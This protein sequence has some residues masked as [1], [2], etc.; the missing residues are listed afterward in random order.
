[1]ASLISQGHNRFENYDDL[2]KEVEERIN[3]YELD[4]KQN[5]FNYS[6]NNPKTYNINE[7]IKSLN[8]NH[9]LGIL[10]SVFKGDSGHDVILRFMFCDKYIAI[11]EI[12]YA[13]RTYF[14]YVAINNATFE[15]LEPINENGDIKL[16]YNNDELLV[17]NVIGE[18]Y[19]KILLSKYSSMK[20]VVLLGI[21]QKNKE[22]NSTYL[23]EYSYLIKNIIYNA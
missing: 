18:T 21:D 8:D 19:V 22:T 5:Y 16:E 9:K 13:D 10:E 1:K 15:I 4:N 17:K 23:D 11:P 20:Y 7:L 6:I 2:L 3:Q 14:V 12:G